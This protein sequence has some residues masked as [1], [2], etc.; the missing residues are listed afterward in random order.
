MKVRKM[1]SRTQEPH[2]RRM[3]KHATV[4]IRHVSRVRKEY[5]VSRGDVEQELWLEFCP[6][7]VMRNE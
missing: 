6:I 1:K 7:K 3:W 4:P 2:Y 5:M